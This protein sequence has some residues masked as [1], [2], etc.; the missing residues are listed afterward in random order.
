MCAKR[1]ATRDEAHSTFTIKHSRLPLHHFLTPRPYATSMKKLLT[2]LL[3]TFSLMAQQPKRV[4][5]R[6]LETVA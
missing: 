2:I 5:V 6:A 4:I 1:L 3:V